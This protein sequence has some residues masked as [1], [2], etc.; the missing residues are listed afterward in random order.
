[1]VTQLIKKVAANRTVLM[2]EHNMSV[3]GSIADMITVLQ[4]G[5]VIAEGPYAEVSRNPQV[6]EAYMGS[7]DEELVGAH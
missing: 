2:V 5:Q 3:V 7:A 4:F 1:M 6:L